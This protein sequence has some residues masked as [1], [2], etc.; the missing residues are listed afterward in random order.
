VKW[1]DFSTSTVKLERIKLT[2]WPVGQGGG[3]DLEKDIHLM[4]YIYDFIPVGW[5]SFSLVSPLH[6]FN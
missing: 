4:C 5:G 1:K 6:F 3:R 2:S